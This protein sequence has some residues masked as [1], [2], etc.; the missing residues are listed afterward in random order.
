[1][2]STEAQNMTLNFPVVVYVLCAVLPAVLVKQ[3]LLVLNGIPVE[4]RSRYT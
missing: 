3:A 4:D 1:M 2:L